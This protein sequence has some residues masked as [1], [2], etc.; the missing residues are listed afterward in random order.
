LGRLLDAVL[1][2]VFASFVVV[3]HNDPDPAGWMGI[4]GAAMAVFAWDA[5]RGAPRWAPLAVAAIALP[6]AAYL[7]LRVAGTPGPLDFGIGQGMLAPRVEET[8]ETGGLVIVV[9]SM[10]ALAV[11]IAR[12]R[13]KTS[14]T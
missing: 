7:G 2:L 10:V 12:R 1:A 13:G 9:V 5:W 11:A 4:Y 3:Q 14:A 8:R 6:W